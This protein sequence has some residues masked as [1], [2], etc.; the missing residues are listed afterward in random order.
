M[1][2][3]LLERTLSLPEAY[4]AFYPCS[5]L[6]GITFIFSV[7]GG[8]TESQHPSVLARMLASLLVVCD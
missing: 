3:L 2:F 1:L 5:F 6:K 8:A 7:F 4:T